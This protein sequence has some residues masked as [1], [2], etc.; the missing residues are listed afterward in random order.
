MLLL[1]TEV[2][3]QVIYISCI[4]VYSDPFVKDLSFELSFR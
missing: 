4:T 1:V 3:R 2:K